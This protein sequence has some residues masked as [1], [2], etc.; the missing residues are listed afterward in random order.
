LQAAV[1]N[2]PTQELLLRGGAGEKTI[3]CTPVAFLYKIG[4]SAI[5]D[6]IFSS[7]KYY[8]VASGAKARSETQHSWHYIKKTGT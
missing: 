1:L 3:F 6:E 2:G 4:E 8:K 5:V 7:Q